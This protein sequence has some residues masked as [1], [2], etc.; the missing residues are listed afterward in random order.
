MDKEKPCIGCRWCEK[1]K[2]GFTLCRAPQ[3]AV[4]TRWGRIAEKMFALPPIRNGVRWEFCSTNRRGHWLDAL[5]T[6]ACGKRGQWFEERE[7]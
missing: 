2:W 1:D 5:I 4:Q 7:G 6:V 3:Q